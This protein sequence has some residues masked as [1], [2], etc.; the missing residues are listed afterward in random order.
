[1]FLK[2]YFNNTAIFNFS[3][4]SF[5][6][7]FINIIFAIIGI[8]LVIII[9]SFFSLN[10]IINPFNNADNEVIVEIYPE[11]TKER[12]NQKKDLV[13]SYLAEQT[14]ISNINVLTNDEILEILHSFSGEFKDFDNQIDLPV[15][16]ILTLKSSA[17]KEDIDSLRLNLSQK[18]NNVYL[19]EKDELIKRLITPINTTKY[20]TILIAL[21]LFVLLFVILFFSIYSVI[22]A[23]KKIFLTLILLGLTNIKL[24]LDFAIWI[25]KKALITSLIIL[26]GGIFIIIL[27]KILAISILFS[28]YFIFI[29]F[30]ALILPCISLLLSIIFAYNIVKKLVRY[31]K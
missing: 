8:T 30:L 29:I 5:W 13:L 24:S 21:I 3:L 27:F 31:N 12:T 9:T 22:F 11:S 6:S 14:I 18:V 19:D 28:K 10:T 20:T 15:V 17:K 25:T 26:C 1:M 7:K 16:I 4:L 23:N 2:K